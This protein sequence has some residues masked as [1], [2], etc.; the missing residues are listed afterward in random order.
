M[1]KVGISLLIV[2]VALAGIFLY[3]I[4]WGGNT[5][6]EETIP[7]EKLSEE[8]LLGPISLNSVDELHRILLTTKERGRTKFNYTARFKDAE[9]N[10]VWSC[11]GVSSSTGEEGGAGSVGSSLRSLKT[12]ALRK[13]GDYYLSLKIDTARGNLR[14]ARI[15][16]K[17][18]VFGGKSLAFAISFIAMGVVVAIVS[19]ILISKG[20]R[21][22]SGF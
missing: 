11:Q 14:S 15:S 2:G 12:F 6:F 4:I 9:G 19:M 1:E 17:E 22:Q 18:K 20:L 7:K 5:V 8:I 16:V 13:A 10:G 21:R 3:L